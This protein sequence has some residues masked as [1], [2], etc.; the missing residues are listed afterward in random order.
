MPRVTTGDGP[1]TVN[2]LRADAVESSVLLI[3]GAAGT[4]A[5]H[6]ARPLLVRLFVGPTPAL[7]CPR[8]ST[9]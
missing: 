8:D 4:T 5:G 6:A 3:T 1:M 2:A 9:S 7:E